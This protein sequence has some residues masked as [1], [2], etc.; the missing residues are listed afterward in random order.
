LVTISSDW[1][2]PLSDPDRDDTAENAYKALLARILERIEE[3]KAQPGTPGV[4]K[5]FL[6]PWHRRAD[7][8]DLARVYKR[9]AH[10][11]DPPAFFRLNYEIAEATGYGCI[12]LLK[13]CAVQIQTDDEQRQGATEMIVRF[14]RDGILHIKDG[15]WDEY[16]GLTGKTNLKGPYI[17]VEDDHGDKARLRRNFPSG[18]PL[19]SDSEVVAAV[20]ADKDVKK[21]GPGWIIDPAR[22]YAARSK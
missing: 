8:I 12:D 17:Y 9:G 11:I 19:V 5:Q 6:L 2:P 7:W 21:W 20:L 4:P 22:N 13:G 10:Q 14:V 15:D 16:P 18:C 3:V 1:P